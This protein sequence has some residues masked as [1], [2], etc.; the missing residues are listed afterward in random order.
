MWFRILWGRYSVRS[1]EAEITALRTLEVR[2]RLLPL[3]EQMEECIDLLR[4]PNLALED[5]HRSVAAVTRPAS[6]PSDPTLLR[7]PGD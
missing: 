5:L 1:K 4:F 6:S 2:S 3:A 7:D